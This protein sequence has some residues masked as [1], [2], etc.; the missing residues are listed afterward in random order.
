MRRNINNLRATRR[1]ADERLEK[2]Q[3][4]VVMVQTAATRLVWIAPG[5]KQSFAVGLDVWGNTCPELTVSCHGAT[6]RGR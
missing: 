6:A 5:N 3:E 4:P 2:L 1:A